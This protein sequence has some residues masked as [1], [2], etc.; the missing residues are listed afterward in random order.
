M[1]GDGPARWVAPG[2]PRVPARR[3]GRMRH[4]YHPLGHPPRRFLPWAWLVLALA[5]IPLAP[6]SFRDNKSGRAPRSSARPA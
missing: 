1:V 2:S 5:V 4:S 3:A 6:R